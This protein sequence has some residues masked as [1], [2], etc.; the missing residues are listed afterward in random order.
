MYRS[1]NSYRLDQ[2]RILYLMKQIS[3]TTLLLLHL[4][5]KRKLFFELDRS[6]LKPGIIIC[7]Q[8]F[9][10]FYRLQIEQRSDVTVTLTTP[11]ILFIIAG[12]SIIRD[13]FI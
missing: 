11:K 2:E 8:K 4:Y 13:N 10:A 5:W 3:L 9:F 7:D 1:L 12:I 6:E